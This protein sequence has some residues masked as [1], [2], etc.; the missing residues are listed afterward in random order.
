MTHRMDATRFTY[1]GPPA[2]A[3]ALAQELEA[4]GLSVDYE[5]PMETKDLALA[6]SAVAV[7][8]AATGPIKDIVSSVSLDLSCAQQTGGRREWVI[9]C[10][11]LV[12]ACR[13]KSGPG[14]CQEAR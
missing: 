4:R 8:F 7:V 10:C 13:W 6:M 1:I 14:S 9:C 5:P 11:Q 12:V 3:G 2:Y